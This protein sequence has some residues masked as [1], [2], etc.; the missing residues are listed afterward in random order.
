MVRD[1]YTC[2]VGQHD[3]RLVGI[4]AL[5]CLFACFTSIDLFSHASE[6]M[7]ARRLK[8]LIAA[9][10]VFGAGVWATHFV[11]ELAYRPGMPLDYAFGPTVASL[12]IAILLAFAGMAVALA[13]SLPAVGGGIV[14]AAVAAMH[15]VGMAALLAPAELVWSPSYVFASIMVGIGLCALALHTACASTSVVSRGIATLLLLGGI[16]GLHFIAMTAVWLEPDPARSMPAQPFDPQLLA[17]AVAAVSGLIIAFGLSGSIAEDRLARQA[18]IEATRLRASEEHLERAQ[19]I[20]RIGSIRIDLVS[21]EAQWSDEIYRIFGLPRDAPPTFETFRSLVHPDDLAALGSIIRELKR[22]LRRATAEFRLVRRDGSERVVHDETEVVSDFAGKPLIQVTTIR[23]ITEERAAAARQREL[24]KRLHHSRQLEALGTLAGGVAHDLNNTLVPIVAIAKMMV[25]ELTP[26]S[27][28][29]ADME[30]VLQAGVRARALVQQIITFSKQHELVEDLIDLGQVARDALHM[31]HASLPATIDLVEAIDNV[32]PTLGDAARL[33]QLVI[34][35]MT[36]AAQAIGENTGTITF[37][38]AREG[39]SGIRL[40]VA[41]TGCGMD[42]ATADRVFQPFFTTRP[43]GEGTGL[44]LSVAHGIV[45]S[46]G[47]RIEVRSKPGVGT[48]LAVFLPVRE[49]RTVAAQAAP[50][51]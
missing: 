16:C 6:T 2:I 33:Q 24:E 51:A 21:G 46:H 29:R 44:G 28:S 12:V 43:V 25:D 27:E 3:L 34:N 35:L 23:D 38:L 40:S 9:S 1:L 30:L 42:Q 31:M 5:I 19:R 4:A 32:P 49:P 45:V 11:A 26:E 48:E 37:T 50:V 36:N 8:W 10:V 47:G 20:A 18:V 15:Y 22:G 17:V 41:D 39:V 7:G 13:Y 14:G